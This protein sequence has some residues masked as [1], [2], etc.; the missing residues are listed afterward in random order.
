MLT[1][2]VR[3][4][5]I[6]LENLALS[7]IEKELENYYS[8]SHNFK[9]KIR[10]QN[11]VNY[12]LLL[13]N[14]VLE[15]NEYGKNFSVRDCGSG[16]QSMTIIALYRLLA[17]LK[18]N[19]YLLGIE[20]PET[21]LHPQ[22]QRE[23][24][25][26]IKDGNGASKEVQVIFTTHSAV[27]SDQLEHTEIVLFRKVNDDSRGMKTISHQIIQDFWTKH[28]L[29]DFKYY[30]FIKYR[31]SEF[32]FAKFII[33]VESKNDAEVVRLLLSQ[34][35]IDIDLYGVSIINLEG[36]KN[37]KYPFYLLSYLKIPYFLILD[38][39]YFIPYSND[40]LKLSR[41]E[42]GFPKYRYEFK[43]DSLVQELIP[44]QK[45]R[46]VLLSLFKTNHSKAMDFLERFNIIC[47]HYSLEVDLVASDKASDEFYRLLEVPDADKSKKQL[48]VD[49]YKQIKKPEN[50]LA[51]LR[52]LPHKNLPNSYKRIKK[53]IPKLI[54]QIAKNEI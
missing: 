4:A 42:S 22:A 54:K 17:Y 25:K 37:M 23:L 20:E 43:N 18:Y 11:L 31:N 50:L 26:T 45:D 3:E 38:K 10:Y 13:N 44:R 16:I 2:K 51:V 9:F 35:K 12:S 47:F 5:T 28:Q 46:D 1:P 39:D 53:V 49:R 40:D 32:F 52:H 33:I 30:Q 24:I 6:N 15:V 48:L 19:N 36:V 41:N 34:S 27:I 7:K 14:I 21:N 29:E 8:L